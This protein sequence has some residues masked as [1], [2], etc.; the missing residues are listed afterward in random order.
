MG[1]DEEIRIPDTSVRGDAYERVFSLRS[2]SKEKVKFEFPAS[3]RTAARGRGGPEGELGPL[4]LAS[5]LLVGQGLLP[6][7]LFFFGQGFVLVLVSE[8]A[9]R[10]DR[11]P[12]E[13]YA[14]PVR[15]PQYPVKA[16]PPRARLHPPA[17]S[18]LLDWFFREKRSPT[19]LFRSSLDFCWV[20]VENPC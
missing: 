5:G 12:N 17:A 15:R 2:H 13:H 3:P 8:D 6:P 4:S 10:H 16:V 1:S 19:S 11:R 18:D 14:Y 7:S 20:C 9:V